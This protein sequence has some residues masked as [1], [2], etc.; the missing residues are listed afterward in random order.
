MIGVVYYAVRNLSEIFIRLKVKCIVYRMY[1]VGTQLGSF[2]GEK[3]FLSRYIGL[4]H[5]KWGSV[6][7]I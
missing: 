1:Y 7:I 4:V 6:F 5:A 2:I 3:Y